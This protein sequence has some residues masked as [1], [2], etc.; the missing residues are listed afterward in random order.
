MSDS[1]RL[2]VA[3]RDAPTREQLVAVLSQLGHNT[4]AFATVQDALNAIGSE[5]VDLVLLGLEPGGP[6]EDLVALEE[7]TIAEG[8]SSFRVLLEVLGRQYERCG[9][10]ITHPG[11]DGRG[12]LE[13]L[14]THINH[15]PGGV[16]PIAARVRYHQEFQSLPNHTV[17]LTFGC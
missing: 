6:L 2:I 4:Q 10:L 8:G 17:W 12:L 3:E 9:A 13:G 15:R 7:R 5:R 11:D 1:A 16:L 14:L